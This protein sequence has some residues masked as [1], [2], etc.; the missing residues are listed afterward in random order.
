[1]VVMSQYQINRRKK[2]TRKYHSV[3]YCHTK[4]QL[5]QKMKYLTLLVGFQSD[6]T[7]P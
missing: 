2:T 3:F 6:D 5:S 4:S 1:M 7:L